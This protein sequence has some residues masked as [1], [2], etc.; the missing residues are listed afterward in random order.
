MQVAHPTFQFFSSRGGALMDGRS[1]A[2]SRFFL[3]LLS[4][5]FREEHTALRQIE[6]LGYHP[7]DVRH[8]V[9]SHLDFDH[10]G[11]LDDFPHATV[12]MLENSCMPLQ[13]HPLLLHL[14]VE[15]A[16]LDR[17]LQRGDEVIPVDRLLNKVG[18]PARKRD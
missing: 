9:L 5:D 7:R 8:I 15:L 17:T 11:G 16:D 12:H 2:L 3:F 10:A 14:A 1:A 6:R 13:V 18:R 4:P